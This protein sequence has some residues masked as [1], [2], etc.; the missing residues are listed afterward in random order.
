MSN[1]MDKSEF[2]EL[3]QHYL[4]MPNCA[5]PSYD[6]SPKRK[7][8]MF[9]DKVRQINRRRRVETPEETARRMGW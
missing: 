6:K 5:I 3:K 2:E 9:Y 4:S 7:M 1:N 8:S